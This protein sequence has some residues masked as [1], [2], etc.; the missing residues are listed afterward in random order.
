MNRSL[1]A[2]AFAAALACAPAFAQTFPDKP[3]KIVVA[4]APGTGSDVLAR[5][6][7]NGM[8]PLLG[9]SVIVD[10]RPG[11]GGIVGTESVARSPA[12]G[13]TVAL[14]TT[15][16]LVTNP[17]LNPQVKYN[18]EKDFAPVAG[19]GKA[20]YV[21]VTANTPE[22]PKTLAELVKRLKAQP[23][24]FG[25]AGQGT[26]THLASEMFLHHLGIT[27]AT[28]VP[29]KGSS[30]A[31]TDVTGGQVLF[32]SDTLAAAL[33]LIRGGKLRALVVTAPERVA[34]LPDVPTTRE[35]GYPELRAHAWL[36]LMAPAGT[37]QPVV[38]KLSDAAIKAMK[39]PEM[40][41]KLKAQELELL[42]LDPRQLGDFI[43]SEA[44]YWNDF[45]KR[46][47]MKAG[48]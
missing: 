45:I 9:Q 23:G 38:A 27:D 40:Q 7:A 5:L 19:L 44:P 37:P 28:H 34:A 8:T 36:V 14:G 33:P 17:A 2:A 24:T 12:D 26:I 32:A 21:L 43:R 15:S 10:N 46:T 11:G 16:T 3:V 13:Y 20:W 25:S 22:A 41:E 35:L 6:V 31:L 42:I 48:N 29:Y 18:V 4:F 39:A 30:Q 1:L 47:G